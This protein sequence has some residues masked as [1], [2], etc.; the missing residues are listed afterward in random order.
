MGFYSSPSHG[1]QGCNTDSAFIQKMHR[2]YL[3]LSCLAP[4]NL[5]PRHNY[6]SGS[7]ECSVWPPPAAVGYCLLPLLGPTAHP[8]GDIAWPDAQAL[9]PH[10][11]KEAVLCPSHHLYK[12]Q[13]AE[14]L[15]CP[16]PCAPTM[17]WSSVTPH[18]KR[19]A[20][21][22]LGRVTTTCPEFTP[23][24]L[25]MSSLLTASQRSSAHPPTARA[26]STTDMPPWLLKSGRVYLTK[27]WV[28][29]Q[30]APL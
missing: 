27:G 30:I 14:V 12:M 17:S 5:S 23:C 19:P 7:W 18:L 16:G 3:S 15:F 21:S 10:S 8:R 9:G 13:T 22:S 6:C 29:I 28:G 4:N 24:I 20:V 11:V 25:T 26:L 1:T 2:L